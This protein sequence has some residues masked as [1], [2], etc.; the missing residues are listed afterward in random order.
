VQDD[1]RV[2]IVESAQP[3]CRPWHD[4]KRLDPPDTHT[5]RVPYIRPCGFG[6]TCVFVHLLLD[7]NGSLRSVCVQGRARRV[8][9]SEPKSSM[10]DPSISY[11]GG[12][13]RCAIVQCMSMAT[14]V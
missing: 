12:L 2:A 4:A 1:V 10:F 7:L 13:M 9:T 14:E 6:V 11:L 3:L 8:H 5:R